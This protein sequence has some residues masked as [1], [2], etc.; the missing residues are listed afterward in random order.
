M[1]FTRFQRLYHASSIQMPASNKRME[2]NVLPLNV[3]LFSVSIMVLFQH[4]K[5]HHFLLSANF[6]FSHPQKL[7]LFTCR[8]PPCP[9][10]KKRCGQDG[11][12]HETSVADR[13]VRNAGKGADHQCHSVA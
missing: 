7:T 2:M 4:A 11:P 3:V 12:Q 6:F 9:Q 8:G 1:D 5:I 13:T 10:R